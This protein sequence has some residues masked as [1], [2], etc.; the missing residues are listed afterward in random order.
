MPGSDELTF[1]EGML[2]GTLQAITALLAPLVTASREFAE[3]LV[4]N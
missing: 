1:E 4:A 2:R 3:N